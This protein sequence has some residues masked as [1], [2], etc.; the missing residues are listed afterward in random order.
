MKS[1]DDCL[2][3]VEP[4]QENFTSVEDTFR[5]NPISLKL[6]H[7]DVHVWRIA[8]A[9]PETT[10]QKLRA[11]LSADE[12]QRATQFKFEKLQKRFV[13][14]RGALRNIL[15]RYTGLAAAEIVFEYEAHGKPKLAV[16]DNRDNLSFN[17]SHSENLA[18]CA[19]SRD[20]A[21]GVDVELVR[22]LDD[23]ERIA[24][25][26]FSARES[27]IFCA[28]PEEQQPSAFFNCWTR[29]EAFI[30]ALGEGLSHPLHRFEVSFIDNAPV[31]LLSTRPDSEEAAKWTLLALA[32]GQN[33]V[34]ALA[35]KRKDLQ[36]Q[37]WQWQALFNI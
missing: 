33:Y 35:V 23:A 30:K 4:A 28:L 9:Q 27:E 37:C 8:L 25:R 15:S 18:L 11:L 7:D 20:C 17:L 1:A 21:V 36:L 3:K 16:A 29:K 32:P 13:V 14:A 22:R 26:F 19:V 2:S 24:R 12:Q 34:G 6:A 10:L 5:A 31:A